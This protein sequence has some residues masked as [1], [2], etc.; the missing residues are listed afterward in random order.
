MAATQRES[1]FF[2]EN[3]RSKVVKVKVKE[4]SHITIGQI[5]FQFEP[6]ETG[7]RENQNANNSVSNGPSK[8]VVRATSAGLLEK[9]YI[10]EGNV[11]DQ[12]YLFLNLF[13]LPFFHLFSL[14]AL[15]LEY[16][17]CSHPTVMKEMCAECGADL[18]ETDQRSQT[19]AVAMVHN[20][21][22]LM[23]SMKVRL[24]ENCNSHWF[25]I[26]LIVYIGSHSVG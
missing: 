16:S 25:S 17:S 21:P 24:T 2:S 4:G 19:A 5:L 3:F 7:I 23:V 15:I 8:F 14:R 1:L 18:R 13:Y 10:K 9:L 22:E 12:G 26:F 20:I 11:I 6:E